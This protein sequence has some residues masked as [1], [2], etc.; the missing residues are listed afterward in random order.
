MISASWV[1]CFDPLLL[2]FFLSALP[3]TLDILFSLYSTWKNS[4]VLNSL[5][6]ADWTRELHG[7]NSRLEACRELKYHHT[8]SSWEVMACTIPWHC[9]SIL[10][11]HGFVIW[12]GLGLTL[13]S[14]LLFSAESL[15]FVYKPTKFLCLGPTTKTKP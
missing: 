10:G 1:L 9:S 6:N 14:F 8:A 12:L 11:L 7:F 13:A 15:W 3:L 2:F 5:W 4:R